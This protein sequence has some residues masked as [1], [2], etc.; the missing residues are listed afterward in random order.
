MLNSPRLFKDICTL[1]NVS[2]D[3]SGGFIYAA[4]LLFNCNWSE[5]SELAITKNGETFTSKSVVY[6]KNEDVAE[7]SYLA[8]GDFVTPGT[9]SNPILDPT[10]NPNTAFR[11]RAFNRSTGLRNLEAI[12]KAML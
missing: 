9:G 11:V 3:G 7:G 1:W 5:K 8:Q 10:T 12:R 4:P 2:S 6:L